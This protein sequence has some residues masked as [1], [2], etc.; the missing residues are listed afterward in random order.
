[1]EMPQS[2]VA[3]IAT[4][5]AFTFNH[6]TTPH[7]GKPIMSE[8]HPLAFRPH[9][10]DEAEALVEAAQGHEAPPP[11]IPVKPVMLEASDG[12]SDADVRNMMRTMATQVGAMQTE[13]ANLKTI[14]KAGIDQRVSMTENPILPGLHHE[15][16]GDIKLPEGRVFRPLHTALALKSA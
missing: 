12:D 6:A 5:H 10:F 1:M 7:S 13:I 14:I 2:I 15:T 4:V 16:G 11:S 9:D 8:M 3:R